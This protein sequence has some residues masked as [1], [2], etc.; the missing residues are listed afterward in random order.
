[1]G[2]E[3]SNADGVHIDASV[4]PLAG[5]DSRSHPRQKIG[6]E[7]SLEMLF[8][9]SQRTKTAAEEAARDGDLAK[10]ITQFTK[11]VQKNPDD[12][13]SRKRL[14]DL[15]QQV[16]DVVEAISHYEILAKAY[17][18]Q[19]LMLRAI[20]ACR[21][22]LELD[23][24]NEAANRTLEA[25]DQKR[26]ST[27]AFAAAK[28]EGRATILEEEDDAEVI[29]GGDVIVE[30][31]ADDDA[32]GRMETEA[33]GPMTQEIDT[34]LVL[35]ERDATDLPRA[36]TSEIDLDEVLEIDDAAMV[37]GESDVVEGI[38]APNADA[39][40]VPAL[41]REV[42]KAAFLEL[43]RGLQMWEVPAGARIIRQGEFGTSCF[44]IAS[45]RV[46]VERDALDDEGPH[47]LGRLGDGDVFGEIALLVRNQR[48]ANVVAEEAT[49]VLEIER[50]FLEELIEKYPS[51][52]D[53]LVTFS[54]NRMLEN[55][56]RTAPLFKDL[57]GNERKAALD[58]FEP[59]DARMGETLLVEGEPGTGLYVVLTGEVEVSK[60]GDDGNIA[61]VR[62]LQEGDVFG[63]MS[64]FFDEPASAT[65]T[66]LR[67]AHLMWLPPEAFS[68][69]CERSPSLT[70]RLEDLSL[71]RAK[72]NAETF[73][74]ERR[75]GPDLI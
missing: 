22:I 4:A 43:V 39:L 27:D 7:R 10:A 34:E 56:M 72:F 67:N 54:R 21:S 35:S 71:E 28:R 6:V 57:D 11:V 1:M 25:L 75:K 13:Q 5:V 3:D 37:V 69:F 65:I 62:S 49:E 45:G 17:A 29:S 53:A 41:F 74:A 59:K 63:E 52:K 47:I 18:E 16:G 46:R 23:A 44:L 8:G 19:G 42:P 51:V 31:A 70:K 40:T 68:A 58:L 64:L 9:N 30:D 2:S 66:V 60:K 15:Y 33:N 32:F 55:L 24:D 61:T 73:E 20:A 48:T 36:V 14:A 26:H 50:A 38:Y 12:L